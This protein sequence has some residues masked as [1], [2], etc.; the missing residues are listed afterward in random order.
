MAEVVALVE[1]MQQR[2]REFPS[3]S[4]PTFFEVI[5]IMALETFARH[6]CDVVLLETGL[7]GRLDATNIVTPMASVITPVDLD[8]QQYLGETLPEIAAEKAGIIKTGVPTVSAPQP[9]E[10]RTVLEARAAEVGG[11]LEFVA[12][13]WP[14]DLPGLPGSHQRW[15]AALACAALRAAGVQVNGETESEGLRRVV[16]PGRFQRVTENLVIDGAHNPEAIGTLVTTWREVFGDG[17]AS[18]V[19]GALRDKDAGQLLHRLRAIADEVWLVPVSSARGSSTAELR[20][21]ADTAGFLAA[22]EGSVTESLTAARAAG[23]PVLASI[24]PGTEISRVLAD[25]SCGL[26]VPPG[27]IDAFEAALSSLL[28]DHEMRAAMGERARA[29]VETWVSPAGVAT[30]YGRLFAE[31]NP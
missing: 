5:T 3:D 28:D 12:E 27:D 19:F 7:G 4:S 18:L 2:L 22:H 31:L 24:D 14:G 13:P 17:R 29:F 16:W 1:S 9:P 23:R 10:V 21:A 6:K 20:P 25:Q 8:H 26:S 30:A 15:N 11:A